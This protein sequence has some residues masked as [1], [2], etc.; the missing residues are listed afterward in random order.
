MTMRSAVTPVADRYDHGR[1]KSG[2]RETRELEHLSIR[3][4]TTLW[5]R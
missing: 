5:W 1:G 2:D 3:R 4:G